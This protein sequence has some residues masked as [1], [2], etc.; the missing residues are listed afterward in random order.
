M[1]S[2]QAFET[3]LAGVEA[4]LEESWTRH[5]AATQQGDFDAMEIELER[6]KNLVSTRQQLEGLQELWPRM[7]GE[8]EPAKKRKRTRQRATRRKKLQRGQKTPEQEFIVPILQVLQDMGGS[9]RAVEVLNRVGQRML[10]TLN[11]FDLS[12]LKTGQLRWRNTTQWARQKMKARGLLAADSPRGIWEITEHG[13]AYLREHAEGLSKPKTPSPVK[14]DMRPASPLEEIPIFAQYKGRLFQA[15]LLP[16]YHVRLAGQEHRSPSGAARSITGRQVNG[17]MFWRYA[18]E[19]GHEHP[20]D[21][22][23]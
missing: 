18:D 5:K 6:Q 22:L 16:N 2:R 20:I 17:W 3:L 19:K 9:G 13:R 12:T 7:V 4:A 10:G 11:E 8:R 1:N 21:N 14:E 15:V 23:R